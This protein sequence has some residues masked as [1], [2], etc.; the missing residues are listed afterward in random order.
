MA[1]G[2]FMRTSFLTIF[3]AIARWNAVLRGREYQYVLLLGHMRSGSTVLSHVLASHPDFVG[4]GEAHIAYQKPEDLRQLIA[5][6]CQLLRRLDLPGT[7]IV[8]QINHPRVSNEVL[9][10][11]IIKKSILLIRE[12][13][14]TLRS[15]IATFGWDV[16]TALGCYVGRLE[17]IR[18]Y[19]EILRDRALLI[20][21][22]DLVNR[23]DDTLAA[24]T[25]FFGLSTPFSA[26]YATHTATQKVGDPSDNISAGRVVRTKTHEIEIEPATLVSASRAFFACREKLI[27]AGVRL[28]FSIEGSPTTLH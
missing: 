15:L 16:A 14:G 10:S 24:L 9:H 20:E 6:T 26:S 17:Q 25:G 19:G 28:P 3:N 11:P 7:H 8:D 27:A 12:P 13:K 18:R 23:T 4:A 2:G 5:R 21:Y 1:A 22:E